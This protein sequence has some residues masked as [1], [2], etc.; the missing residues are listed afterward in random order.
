MV[1]G[2]GVVCGMWYV[3]CGMWYVVRVRVRVV[4]V[5]T[6]LCA[7]DVRCGVYVVL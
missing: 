1:H 4:C 6:W 3:V 2:V 5:L 7:C